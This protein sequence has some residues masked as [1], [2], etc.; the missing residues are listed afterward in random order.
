MFY[1]LCIVNVMICLKIR[2]NFIDATPGKLRLQTAIVV[3]VKKK[4]I[5]VIDQSVK[6]HTS[7]TILH[8]AGISLMSPANPCK[9]QAWKYNL[10]ELMI[11]WVMNE[12]PQD[13]VQFRQSAECATNRG[14]CT[15]DV[16]HSRILKK[17][18]NLMNLLPNLLHSQVLFLHLLKII[19]QVLTCEWQITTSVAPCE[20]L[21]LEWKKWLQ[22]V[23]WYR[24]HY[25]Q[26]CA[27]LDEQ[28]RPSPKPTTGSWIS[29]RIKPSA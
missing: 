25:P 16:P 21:V 3:R 12:A 11:S 15:H 24:K 14:T 5:I 19:C 27:T 13:L 29:A 1:I 8:Y 2:Y 6:P 7:E 22:P 23:T 10:V 26:L 20:L 18:L 4:L 9:K 28:F 17:N